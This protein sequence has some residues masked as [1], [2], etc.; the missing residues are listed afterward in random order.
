MA[1]KRW[2]ANQMKVRGDLVIDVGAARALRERNVSL[3]AAGV[4][5]VRGAFRRGE[6]VACRDPDGLEVARGLVNYAAEEID[7]LKGR[8]SREIESILGYVVEPEMI[9]RD[10]MVITDR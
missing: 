9:D 5:A 7:R 10:N 3:L 4:Q 1:R 8:S 2:L 6:V